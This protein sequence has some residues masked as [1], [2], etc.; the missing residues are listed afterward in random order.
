MSHNKV[1]KQ[2]QLHMQDSVRCPPVKDIL[3]GTGEEEV[4]VTALSRGLHGEEG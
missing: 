4:P 1:A 2:P 3:G